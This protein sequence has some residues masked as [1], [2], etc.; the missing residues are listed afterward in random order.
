MPWWQHSS[1][2]KRKSHHAPHGDVIPLMQAK[3]YFHYAT[4]LIATQGTGQ[5]RVIAMQG[6]AG[7]NIGAAPTGWKVRHAHQARIKPALPNYWI[8]PMKN[9]NKPASRIIGVD[10]PKSPIG[11]IWPVYGNK[12]VLASMPNMQ[13]ALK[14]QLAMASGVEYFILE[15]RDRGIWQ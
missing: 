4:H 5:E 2:V 7:K 12:N 11:P 13:Y 6:V 15:A 9:A 14:A 8:K 10:L 3:V 1:P